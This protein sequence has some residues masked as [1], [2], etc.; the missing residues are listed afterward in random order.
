[1]SHIANGV[2]WINGEVF[3]TPSGR[4]FRLVESPD[5][6]EPSCSFCDLDIGDPEICKL[7][8]DEELLYI[9]C[10]G[11]DDTNSQNQKV[12]HIVEII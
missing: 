7:D 3:V 8:T 4:K 2:T 1:M 12:Y 9:H 5:C 11:E 10:W 6:E